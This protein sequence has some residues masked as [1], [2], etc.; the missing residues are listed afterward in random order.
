MNRILVIDDHALVRRGLIELLQRLPDG[1]EFGEAGT[2]EAGLALARSAKWDVV[3]LDLGLPDRHGL[4]VLRELRASRPELPV[5]I[6]TMFPEDQ[7]ALRVLEIG[8]AGYLTKESAPEELLRALER[9]MAGHKYLSPA[10]A[11]AVADGLGGP[12]PPPHEQLSD[13]ELEVLRL[14]AAG[15]PITSISKQLGLSPKTVTTYRARL[16]H[17]LRM[18]SNAELTFYATQHGLVSPAAL[19]ATS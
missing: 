9:V 8:A 13:R 14:L 19:R 2:A 15:R 1:V 10:M 4:D 3:L 18:K 7:L 11:Q 17:K 16:L 5:L 12:P 6:L